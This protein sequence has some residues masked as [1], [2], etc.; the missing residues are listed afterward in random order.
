[1]EMGKEGG[2]GKEG[3]VFEGNGVRSGEILMFSKK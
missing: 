1:M 3:R 2:G